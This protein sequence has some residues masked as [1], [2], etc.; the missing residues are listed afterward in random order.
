MQKIIHIGAGTG[1]E[2]EAYLKLQPQQILLLEPLP[3]ASRKLRQSLAGMDVRESDVQILEAAVTAD[4][5]GSSLFEYNLPDASSLRQATELKALFP[6]LKKVAT[7]SVERLAPEE[8]VSRYGPEEG[9]TAWLVVQA[10]GEAFGIIKS[11]ADKKLLK[12]FERVSFTANIEPCYAGS[13]GAEQTLNL[14]EQ[15]GY[16]LVATSDQ[17]PDWPSWTLVRSP[18]QERIDALE[19][20]LEEARDSAA[21]ALAVRNGELQQLELKVA[22]LQDES[23]VLEERLVNLQSERDQV[24]QALESAKAELI[25]ADTVR[26]QQQQYNE[27]LQ[28]DNDVLA[29]ERNQLGA[30]LKEAEAALQQEQAARLAVD[31]ALAAVKAELADAHTALKQQQQNND[32]LQMER[33]ALVQKGDELAAC[34]KETETALQQAQEAYTAADS[35][36]GQLQE[37]H[38]QRGLGHKRQVEALQAENVEL[39]QQIELLQKTQQA[40]ESTCEQLRERNHS[41]QQQLEQLREGDSALSVLEE[42]MAQMFDQQAGLLQQSVS[43]LGQHVTRSFGDQRQHFQ[44]LNGL[45]SYL[46]TGQQPLSFGDWAIDTELATR[47]VQTLE[48]DAFDLVIE[49]GS[50]TSTH[51][52]ARVLS[53]R[54]AAPGRSALEYDGQGASASGRSG[55]HAAIGYAGE[56]DLP[57][58]I[59][60]FEQD[61][62]HLERTR[63]L[64]AQE[65]LT[66]LV[67]LVLA[68]LVPTP[69]TQQTGQNPLFYACEQKLARIAQ[70]FEGRQARVLVLVDGPFS[71]Q[72][73]PLAREPALAM[74]L[75]HLSVHQLSILLDDHKREGEQQVANLWQ[76]LCEQRGLAWTQQSLN[77]EKGALWVTINP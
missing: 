54:V 72:D 67:D 63:S 61:K 2:L 50:G 47:L 69:L 59:L 53:N 62:E 14:L 3:G 34:L 45:N 66:H 65:G 76:Q 57:Q 48:A 28:A 24:S 30:R 27:T 39:K 75:Q 35:A 32:S 22:R 56:Q 10:P 42:R 13:A 58:R 64:L 5:V 19:L 55:Q 38:E 1:A 49:F 12:R 26:Q 15:Q 33:D 51:L 6:G 44:A 31:N 43:A 18:L 7:H 25:E 46:E 52:M 17:D 37:Q 20:Q 36:L 71:P 16:E 73:D 40:G 11:L 41:L 70:L 77:T 68:P 74:V 29:Q 8:L 60:S 21:N 23:R 9:E 4:D